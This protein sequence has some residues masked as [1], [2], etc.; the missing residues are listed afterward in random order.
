MPGFLIPIGHQFFDDNGDPLNGG[1]LY[2]YQ[3]GTSTPLS[4][5]T[6]ENLDV[7]HAN[8]AVCDAAGRLTAFIED[9]ISYK[10]RLFTSADVLVDEWDEVAV[11]DIAAPAAAAEVPT[12]GMIPYGGTAAPSGWLLCD[13]S[14][15]SR[16]TYADLF[17]ALSTRF[18]AG[19]GTTTFNV[20]DMR[21]KFALG[22]ATSGTG[23]TLGG[24]GGTIDHVH[25]G[26]AHTHDPGTLAVPSGGAHTHTTGAPSATTASVQNGAGVT[27]PTDTHTHDIASSGAHTHTVTGATASSGT[28]NTGTANPP[29]VAVNWI[30]KT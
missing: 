19:N 12:G 4:I 10:F 17:A 16:T 22:V 23:S 15:V 1:K 14:A 2:A 6:T 25:T 11:P 29:F 28:G 24:S 26:P 5:Y 27:S 18:G 30:V 9:G 8:P 7:P 13:G 3:A 21:G 20:P